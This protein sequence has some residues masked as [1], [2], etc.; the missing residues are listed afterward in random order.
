M[1]AADWVLGTMNWLG[2]VAF[3]ALAAWFFTAILLH[4]APILGWV[5]DIPEGH[6]DE[7]GSMDMRERGLR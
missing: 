5:E 4:L 1:T 7:Y 3:T 2:W 6:P